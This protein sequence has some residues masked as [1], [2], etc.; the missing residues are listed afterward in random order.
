MD[1]L[2]AITT[3]TIL[4][5]AIWLGKTLLAERLKASIGSEISEELEKLRSEIREKEKQIDL[6]R[7]GALSSSAHRRNS[8]YERK[9]KAVEN[10]WCAITSMAGA[11]NISAM[12]ARMKYDLLQKETARNETLRSSFNNVG[13]MFDLT[14]LDLSLADNARPFLTKMAW[15]YYSAYTAIVFQSV[16]RFEM[17]KRGVGNDLS[18]NEKV[19]ALVKKALPQYDSYIEEFSGN[20]LH[21]LLDELKIRLLSE[22]ES[23]LNG[24][25]EDQESIKCAAEI[26]EAADRLRKNSYTGA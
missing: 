11:E 13:A 10:I 16:V 21:Y 24:E 8:L 22:L 9:V 17:L 20:T 1:W 7:S 14:K 4:G 18:D 2:P 19:V 15:A 23:I 12:L 26:L 6:L 5:A 25:G 3:T